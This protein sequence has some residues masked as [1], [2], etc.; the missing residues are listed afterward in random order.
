MSKTKTLVCVV[1]GNST[2]YSGEFL[3]RK[4]DEYITE[5]FNRCRKEKTKRKLLVVAGTPKEKINKVAI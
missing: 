5:E 3:Q 4:I 2:V 1:T